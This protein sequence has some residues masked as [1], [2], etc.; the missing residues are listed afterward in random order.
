[1][2]FLVRVVPRC[3]GA[4]R[5]PCFARS[6]RPPPS[7]WGFRETCLPRPEW[8]SSW[9]RTGEYAT[10]RAECGAFCGAMAFSF[11]GAFTKRER[12]RSRRRDS[13][14]RPPTPKNRSRTLSIPGSRDRG[15]VRSGNTPAFPVTPR[16]SEAEGAARARLPSRYAGNQSGNS[17]G[18]VPRGAGE[19][20]VAA[21]RVRERPTRNRRVF[22]R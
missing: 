15:K 13:A 10:A 2:P 14:D 19:R 18:N 7:A 5:S 6:D 8:S 21:S 16:R 20:G 3:F 22:S 9:W 17:S 4:K 1:M 12:T 11:R